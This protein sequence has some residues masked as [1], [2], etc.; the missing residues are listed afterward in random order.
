MSIRRSQ[1]LYKPGPGHRLIK[2]LNSRAGCK[3]VFART[4]EARK[5]GSLKGYLVAVTN[6]PMSWAKAG[7]GKMRV[8]LAGR[9]ID[10]GR[11]LK[12]WSI[13]FQHD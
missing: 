12:P 2:G 10:G 7:D 11:S 1:A 6:G 9:R 13:E 5:E 4:K 3:Q 8:A